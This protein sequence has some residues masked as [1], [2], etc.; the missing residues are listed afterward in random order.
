MALYRCLMAT[1]P[2]SHPDTSSEQLLVG[3]LLQLADRPARL[4]LGG[5]RVLMLCVRQLLVLPL[6][7]ADAIRQLLP[8]LLGAEQGLLHLGENILCER[9]EEKGGNKV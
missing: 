1:R 4:S 6:L 3:L 5:Q 8:C 2:S 9:S 7:S